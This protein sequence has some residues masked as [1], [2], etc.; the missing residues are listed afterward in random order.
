MIIPEKDSEQ[1]LKELKELI[2]EYRV[3][4]RRYHYARK[5]NSGAE[6][7]LPELEDKKAAVIRE[8]TDVIGVEVKEINKKQRHQI[9][10]FVIAANAEGSLYMKITEMRYDG[11][12]I[13]DEELAEEYTAALKILGKKY[14]LATVEFP[15]RD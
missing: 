7:L 14:F 1:R 13:Y 15:N 3:I 10:D 6:K 4:N 2:A 12:V 8:L 5:M 11:A 9:K